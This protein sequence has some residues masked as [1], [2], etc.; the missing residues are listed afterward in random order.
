MTENRNYKD[1]MFRI[2]FRDKDKLL[3]LY[4]A[5]N[6]TH[7]TDVEN[8]RITTLENA[9][10]MN[11]KNDLSFVFDFSLS[12]YEHQSTMNPNIPLRDLFYVSKV[13]QGLTKDEDL[14]GSKE[15]KIPTPRFIVFYNGREEMPEKWTRKLSDL[16]EK[17]VAEPELELIV[18]VYNVNMG[19]NPSLFEACQTLKEYAQY[20]ALVRKYVE[21]MPVEEAVECAVTECIQKGILRDFLMQNRAE[22]IEVSIFEYNEEQHI[23][24]EKKISYEDGLREGIEKGI[25]QGIEQGIQIMILDNIEEGKTKEQVIQKLVR[26][27]NISQEVAESYCQKILK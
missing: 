5:V 7:Y 8:L 21:N 20:V 23:K 25:E 4:N 12:I 3:S 18:T 22:A 13:L 6:G 24:N 14:Y 27:F 10:Y 16:Y 17:N 9:I 26:R 1:T 19:R 11:M 2:L 15:V